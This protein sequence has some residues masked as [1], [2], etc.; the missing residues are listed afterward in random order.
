MNFKTTGL[1]LALL[2]IVSAVWLLFPRAREPAT[3]APP[4]PP[5]S[6]DLKYV[7]DPQPKDDQLVR[8]EVERPGKPRMVFERI[9][10]ETATRAG[11][12]WRMVEPQAVPVDGYKVLGLLRTVTGLQSRTRFEPGAKGHLT[13]AEAG[14]EPP[15]AAITL[16]DKEGKQYR[17]EVGKKAIMSSDTYVRAGGQPTIQVAVRDLEPQVDKEVKDYRAQRLF[18]LNLDEAVR[19]RVEHEGRTYDFSRNPDGEWVVNEPLRTRADRTK[20]REKLLSPLNLLQAVEFVDDAPQSLAQYGLDE[21]FLTLTVT[22]ETKR[23]VTPEEGQ[24]E[25]AEPPS[26]GETPVPPVSQTHRLLIGGFAD[27][28]SE[29]RY[30]QTGDGPWVVT[31]TQTAIANLVPNL[32][33]LRDP[34][35]TR[36]KAADATELELTVGE[37]TT[38]LKKV[39]GVWRGTGDLAELETE[40]VTDVLDAIENLTAISYIDQPQELA[41]YG[42]DHPRAVLTVTTVGAVTPITLKIGSETASGRNAYVQREGEPTVV[43]IAEAQAARLAVSPLS[44]RSREIF[45]FPV[46][47]LRRM[48]VQRGTARYALLRAEDRWELV[49][50]ADAPADAASVRA[51]TNDLSRLRAKRVVGK[52]DQARFGL[53]QPAVSI[54]FE[55]SAVPPADSQAATA[56]ASAP[57]QRAPSASEGSEGA[58]TASAQPVAGAPGSSQHELRIAWRDGVAYACKDDDPYIF[59]L[60]E[61]VYRVMTAELIDPR[62]FSFKPE[63]VVGVKIVATGGTLELLREGKT[64]K[65]APDPFVELSQKKVEDFIRDLTQMRAEEYLA[66]RDGDLAAAGLTEPPASATIRLTDGRELVLHLTQ[67]RPGE[68]PRRAALVAEQRIFRM[69]QADCEKL[70]RGLDQYVKS[71]QPEK[72]APPEVPETP[73]DFNE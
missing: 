23:T 8:M 10:S 56:P 3:S 64:W 11:D 5:T 71:G 47:R 13:A 62:L 32:S 20:I 35:V 29:H 49:A 40:A 37:A 24:A 53:E 25:D 57:N 42:L 17:L 14:L 41:Q 69:R 68:L 36:V 38:T 39:D 50:P 9:E 34:R 43:V 55:L 51:L 54:R 33:E 30:A 59:E 66:Y 28:K 26:T 27:L 70:L 60:D 1:L 58:P 15:A 67:E 45:T 6:E 21:P 2:I 44:L 22:T 18:R 63:N 31:V 65:Y 73:T 48:H 52:D 61:T 4:A 16:A 46:D 19:I 12:D 7:F 72:S